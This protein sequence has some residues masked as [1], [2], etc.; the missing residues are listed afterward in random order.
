MTLSFIEICFYVLV[1]N[2]TLLI[3]INIV[4]TNISRVDL[5]IE[6]LSCLNFSEDIYIKDIENSITCGDCNKVFSNKKKLWDH[7]RSH[8]LEPSIC[9][10]CE[11]QFR[12]KKALIDHISKRH[13]ITFKCTLCEEHIVGQAKYEKHLKDNHAEEYKIFC[14]KKNNST[15]YLCRYCQESL[16]S[17]QELRKH[18]LKHKE[19]NE[20]S[21]VETGIKKPGPVPKLPE[22][23]NKEVVCDTCGKH[24][25][26][27]SMKQHR[28]QH[29]GKDKEITTFFIIFLFKI[30]I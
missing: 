10:F 19:L 7:A 24:V 30:F 27:K 1:I 22:D 16:D 18:I 23:K 21:Y 13:K 25:K 11:K 15:G 14:N 29:L 3:L 20:I 17:Q 2:S 9:E 8:R 12:C 4:V 26:I 5:K 28:K 6:F